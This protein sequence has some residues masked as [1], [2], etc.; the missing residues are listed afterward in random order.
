MCYPSNNSCRTFFVVQSISQGSPHLAPYQG[1]TPRS[2]VALT[3]G[4]W[5]TGQCIAI[6]LPEESWPACP[7]GT[8][9]PTSA[10]R[11]PAEGHRV[12][13]PLQALTSFFP[14]AVSGTRWLVR[15]LSPSW[16][17]SCHP[18][19]LFGWGSGAASCFHVCLVWNIL[20]YQEV[21]SPRLGWWLS[22]VELP[23]L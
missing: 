19:T 4:L 16:P 22:R 5:W 9:L 23:F 20:D 14:S 3:G 12:T 17:K 6:F 7:P 8:P 2:Q 1:P 13:G 11:R 10:N 18:G 15:V 21:A